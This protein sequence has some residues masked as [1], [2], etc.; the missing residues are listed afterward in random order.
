VQA[1]ITLTSSRSP[2]LPD[3]L[4]DDLLVIGVGAFHPQ[5]AE[6]PPELLRS[7]RIIVDTID[8]ARAEAGDLIQ[9]GIDWTRVTELVDHLDASLA[10]GDAAPV[11]KTV[12]SAAWDLAAAHVARH[13]MS[14]G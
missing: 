4:P 13:V 7:R 14:G 3:G 9:A 1:L 5:L 2:L 11:F 6:L 8:G 10:A 12:G